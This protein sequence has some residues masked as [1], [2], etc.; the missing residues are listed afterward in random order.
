METQDNGAAKAG[1]NPPSSANAELASA[2]IKEEQKAEHETD[3]KREAKGRYANSEESA[4]ST[5]IDNVKEE[6]S[7]TAQMEEGTEGLKKEIDSLKD[8]LLRLAADF[9]NYRKRMIKE[10]AEAIEYANENLLCDILDPLDNL[11]RTLDAAQTAD[12]T[13]V[14]TIADGVKMTRDALV[15]VLTDKYALSSFGK[16]G[17]P[18][19]ADDHQALCS[20]QAAEG[21]DIEKAMIKEVYQKGYKLHGKVIRHAKV[22]TVTPKNSG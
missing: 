2:D 3:E 14:K 15:K 8:Q 22:M 20:V 7:Q 21:E 12:E 18:F 16:A 19:N 1:P 11:D 13:S 17:E 4:D 10:K 9:D 6:S 5:N